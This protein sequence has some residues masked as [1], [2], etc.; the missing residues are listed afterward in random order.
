MEGKRQGF[1][2][3]NHQFGEEGMILG[4]ARTTPNEEGRGEEVGSLTGDLRS[5]NWWEE[6]LREIFGL[7]EKR[8]RAFGSVEGRR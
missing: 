2:E 7:R 1:E 6:I 4:Q 5:E 3:L 8:W